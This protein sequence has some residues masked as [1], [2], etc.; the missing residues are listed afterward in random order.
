MLPEPRPSDSPSSIHPYSTNWR[1]A[2]GGADYNLGREGL[3]SI[4]STEAA[5]T[6]ARGLFLNQVTRPSAKQSLGDKG[7][8][9]EQAEPRSACQHPGR[10]PGLESGADGRGEEGMMS[11]EDQSPGP[12]GHSLS[13]H[14]DERGASAP[15]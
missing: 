11:L 12:T 9:L 2:G 7:L 8:G 10:I 4:Q 15:C 6:G 1:L 14:Q 5:G 3:P 13:L